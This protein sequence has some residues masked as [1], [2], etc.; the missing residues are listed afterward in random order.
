MTNKPDELWKYLE[1]ARQ[2]IG[3]QYEAYGRLQSKASTLLG[4]GFVLMGFVINALTRLDYMGFM[5]IPIGLIFCALVLL[6]TAYRTSAVATAPN[7]SLIR[8]HLEEGTALEEASA[9]LISGMEDAYTEIKTDLLRTGT[10]VNWAIR[11]ILLGTA[12]TAVMV[13][14]A[15]S[16]VP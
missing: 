6:A 15:C 4:F 10:K 9:D 8:W 3:R 1:L 13:V 14:T 12:A 7:I 5:W 16:C 11:L 2:Q